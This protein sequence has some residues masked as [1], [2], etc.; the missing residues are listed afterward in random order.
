M[1]LLKKINNNY[2][3]ALDSKGEQIIVEGKGIG[4]QK[5]PCE[6]TDLSVIKRTYYHTKEQDIALIQDISQDLLDV[7]GQIFEYAIKTVGERIN[8][9][10]TFILADHIQ[11]SIERYEKNIDLKMPIYYDIEYLY[12]KESKVA[13]YAMELIFNDLHILL[14]DHEKTGIA[15]NIINSELYQSETY[16]SHEELVELCT[17]VIE[18]SM[19]MKIRRDT[20][21]YSRFVTHLHYLFRRM[22]EGKN[23]ATENMKLYQTISGDYPQVRRCVDILENVLQKKKFIMNEEEKVYL[24]MHINRLCTREDCNLK[25]HNPTSKD[26]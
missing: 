18:K 14:P 26:K 12:P 23:V 7:C 2:A 11:F 6:L 10:L 16:S 9:N 24:M 5:M 3:L 21:H 25:E 8:P 13:Q 1:K 19:D 20:F 17:S 22:S 4:F 15:M